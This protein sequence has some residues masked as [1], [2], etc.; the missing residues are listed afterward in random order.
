MY[1][2]QAMAIQTRPT[3]ISYLHHRAALCAPITIGSKI[4]MLQRI[5]L[6]GV[7][8][9]SKFTRWKR[10]KDFKYCEDCESFSDFGL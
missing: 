3:R 8:S 7:M 1:L 5:G 9:C 6:N 2:L 4:T 10:P